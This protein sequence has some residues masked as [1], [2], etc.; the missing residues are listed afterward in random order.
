LSP[1]IQPAVAEAVQLHSEDVDTDT[2][3]APPAAAMGVDGAVN[4]TWHLTGLGP[5][6]VS[7]LVP[8]AATDNA[9]H[10]TTGEVQRASRLEIG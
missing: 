7:D 4:E 5:V 10:T 1:V 2:V 3:P 6:L 9:A 8:H